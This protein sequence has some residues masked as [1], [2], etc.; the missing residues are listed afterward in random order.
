MY[1]RNQRGDTIIEVLIAITVVSAVLGSAYAI[2]NRTVNNSQ[3]A[4]EHSQALKVAEEQL[5]R[6]RSSPNKARAFTTTHAFCLADPQTNP[7]PV[8]DINTTTP[9]DSASLPTTAA[10]YTTPECKVSSRYLVGITRNTDNTFKVYITWDG[11]TGGTDLV[12]L[13]YRLYP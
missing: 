11:A 5:E 8:K 13:S 10:A 4:K 12:N 3:Q 9:V 6:L 1:L 7:E 2:V